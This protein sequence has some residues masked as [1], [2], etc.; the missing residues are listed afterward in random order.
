MVKYVRGAK[1]RMIKLAEFISQLSINCKKKLSQDV[2]TRWNSTYVMLESALQYK[3]ALSQYE[4]VDKNVGYL[5]DEEW[6]KVHKICQFLK[7]FYDITVLFSGSQ[8]PTS[9][10]YF[11]GVYKIQSLISNEM[12]DEG[13]ILYQTAFEMNEKFRKYWKNYSLILSFAVILDPRYKLKFVEYVFRKIYPTNYSEKEFESIFC[14]NDSQNETKS[15]LH[16]YLEE[17]KLD[18]RVKLDVLSFWRSNKSKYPILSAMTRDILSMPITTVASE[19]SFSIRSQII[20]KYRG[21]I[22]PDN[23]EALLCTRNW[24]YGAKGKV[25]IILICCII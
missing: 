6:A 23:A 1:G 13:S 9:N 4:L 2:P 12:Q 3:V 10:L 15:Q 16:L 25:N 14:Q 5:T 18:A 24:L 22:T 8:Y 11:R 17:S 21:S 19:S 20:S 7:P